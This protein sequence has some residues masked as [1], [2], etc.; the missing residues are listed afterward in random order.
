[1]NEFLKYAEEM[2]W[3]YCQSESPSEGQTCV[4]LETNSPQDQDFIVTI[5]FETDNESD[6][7]NKLEE[8]WRGFNPS[9]EAVNWIGHDGHGTNGAPHD[10]Q[11]IL[12]DMVDCKEMLRELV[13]AYHNHAFQDKKFENYR[14]G[15]TCN[16]DSYNLTD[17]E[18]QAVSNI[19]TSIENARTYS[20]YLHNNPVRWELDDMLERF[21]N[22]VRDKLESA[23]TNRV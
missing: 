10:L 12:N 8:Y 18:L 6:F 4:E 21:K 20:S 3:S 14:N 23:F 22:E 15:L 1:M 17:G 16:S 7:A 9:E 19:L 5:W 11:D 2:N 13:V